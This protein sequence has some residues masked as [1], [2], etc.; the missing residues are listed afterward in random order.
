MDYEKYKNTYQ[1]PLHPKKPLLPK[2]PTADDYRK[3]SDALDTY[4]AELTE[5]RKSVAI[6][7]RED[8][9]LDGLFWDDAFKELEIPFDHPKSSK[10]ISWAWEEGHAYGYQEVFSKLRDVW[11]LVK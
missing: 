9:R 6:C 5:Y 4:V 3:Y 1:F 11:E 8:S 10:M 7:R 2:N